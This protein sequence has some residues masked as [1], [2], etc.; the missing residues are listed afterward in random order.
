MP[1]ED[2]TTLEIPDKAAEKIV[3]LCLPGLQES[4][5]LYDYRQGRFLE[6]RQ[7]S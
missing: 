6:F 1:G 4:G 7:P 3:E 5:K 2:P